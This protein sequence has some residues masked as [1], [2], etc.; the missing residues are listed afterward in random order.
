MR[1]RTPSTTASSAA[2]SPSWARATS[3]SS[4]DVTVCSMSST[5]APNGAG[6]P[7]A[8]ED[9]E[10]CQFL[11]KGGSLCGKDLVCHARQLQLGEDV[12]GPRFVGNDARVGDG[13]DSR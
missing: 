9:G 4:D 7:G 3:A 8:E 13:L 12:L 10:N 1:S 5:S 11:G 6:S 2:R